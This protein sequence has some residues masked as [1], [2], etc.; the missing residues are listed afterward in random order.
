MVSGWTG[1]FYIVVEIRWWYSVK[2][3]PKAASKKLGGNVRQARKL[4]KEE[5]KGTCRK[6][7]MS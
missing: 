1:E 4:R 2:A 3:D 6:R 7:S 5:R